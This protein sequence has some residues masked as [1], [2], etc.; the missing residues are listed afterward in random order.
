[1]AIRAAAE[2]PRK[3][4]RRSTT[5]SSGRA[6]C[7]GSWCRVFRLPAIVA[8]R[9]L[10]ITV[11]NGS[12]SSGVGARRRCCR[13]GCRRLGSRVCVARYARSS[14]WA[15][16]TAA[17]TCLHQGDS[18]CM[19]VHD[20]DHAVWLSPGE[21][22]T[23]RLLVSRDPATTATIRSSSTANSM[24]PP[25]AICRPSRRLDGRASPIPTWS[26]AT[27]SRGSTTVRLGR[28]Q[29]GQVIGP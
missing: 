21:N 3:L 10:R 20:Q 27:A 17:T 29:V 2:G 11:A 28:D 18:S 15:A 14:S 9:S 25:V 22:L 12:A 5:V 16:T 19:Q 8:R 7:V 24:L 13:G 6:T 26:D 23:V 4:L 1:M